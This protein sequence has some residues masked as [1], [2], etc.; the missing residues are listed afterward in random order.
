M[1]ILY[2]NHVSQVS[3]AEQSLLAMAVGVAQV[4]FEPRM[5]LPPGGPL[6][7]RCREL[8]LPVD[9][10]PL[11]RLRRTRN[12]VRWAAMAR[13]LERCARR[14]VRLV[15][16]HGVALVHSNSTTAHLFAAYARRRLNVPLVWHVR[17]LM[18]PKGLPSFLG[19]RADQVVAI[20]P[21]VVRWLTAAGVPPDKVAMIPPAVSVPETSGRAGAIRRE[22]GVDAGD[23][24][25]GM[26]AQVVPWKGHR[27]FLAA[28]RRVAQENPSTRFVLVGADLFDEHP[29]LVRR[30]KGEVNAPPLAGRTILA[31]YREDIGDV[32]DALD[33]LVL[34]SHGE[35]FGRALVEAM[36]LGKPVIATKEGGPLEI[37]VDGETGI[38]VP[39]GAPEALAGAML[40][41]ARDGDFARRLGETGRVRAAALF[42]V[43]QNVSRTIRVY[44]DLIP[45]SC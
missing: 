19:K 31:G 42:N 44:Q 23:V 36:L 45:R 26:V 20:S 10:L 7:T 5:G 28:A 30:I 41:L 14:L 18:M 25:F 29:D 8:G 43:Q 37:V 38:L 6:V 33:C 22:W 27:D 16:R 12:P 21:A 11:A 34:P 39:V 32:L 4:G 35:P 2:L 13:L 15:G 24:L 1:R 3:G 9:S 40:T 17:D